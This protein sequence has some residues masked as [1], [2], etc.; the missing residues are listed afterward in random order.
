MPCENGVKAGFGVGKF[1]V[2]KNEMIFELFFRTNFPHD[3][4][5]GEWGREAEVRSMDDATEKRMHHGCITLIVT[6]S[7]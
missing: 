1:D 7:A 6:L 5:T 2:C 3:K 4:L